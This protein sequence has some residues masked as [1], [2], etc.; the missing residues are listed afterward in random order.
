VYLN[1]PIS[2]KGI[3]DT[4]L[5]GAIG[6]MVCDGFDVVA[7][8]GHGDAYPG[9]P[10]HLDIIPAVTKSDGPPGYQPISGK[11]LL[12]S[13]PFINTARID[14]NKFRTPTARLTIFQNIIDK[15]GFLSF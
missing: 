14:V 13:D 15:V 1:N 2:L 11:K 8:I 6:Y 4:I 12:H 3:P 7:G 10:Q 9:R 5:F